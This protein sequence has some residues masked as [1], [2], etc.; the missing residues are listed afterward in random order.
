MHCC[1]STFPEVKNQLRMNFPFV[2]VQTLLRG[3][4]QDEA[5]NKQ[6]KMTQTHC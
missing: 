4:K 3:H 1:I 5:A 2:F 6:E